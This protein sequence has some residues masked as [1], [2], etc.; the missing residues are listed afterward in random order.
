MFTDTI[1]Y[2]S[3]QQTRILREHEMDLK[4]WDGP[5]IEMLWPQC[6]MTD[7]NSVRKAYN[8]FIDKIE[9]IR[10]QPIDYS[11]FNP[12]YDFKG[13]DVKIVPDFKAPETIMGRCPCP[14]ESETLRCCNLKTL[15]AVQQCAFAC[16]Y[17]SIQSFYSKNEIRVV[18]DLEEQLDS[19]VLDENV[20]HI[21]TGQS[22]DSLLLG[23]DYGTIKALSKFALKHPDVVVELKTKS[24]RTD[25]IK[26]TLPK[27]IV[28]TW[29][30]NAKTI[31][32]KEEH[33][34]ASRDSR[35]SAAKTCSEKGHLV[36]FH[37]HP[38]VYFTD[39]KKEYSELVM[40]LTDTID[41]KMAVMVGMG[42]LTFTKQNLKTLRESGRPTCVTHMPLAPIAGKYSYSNA[43]KQEMFSYIYECFPKEWKDSVFFYLCMEDK[44]LWPLCLGR[45][46]P[47][48]ASFEADM[49][50]HYLNKIRMFDKTSPDLIFLS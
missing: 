22:S 15:D 3:F 31:C 11:R 46:Y 41:P 38:V 50:R 49:K 45:E 14:S 23:D 47:D 40:K 13:K 27:N 35:I 16:A 33:L 32:E 44:A 30:L 7:K 24:A 26:E 1:P 19:I 21:G 10:K 36:G 6:D 39:W 25:W 34:A 12:T 18:S 48:N 20:W 17:C 29:S 9:K 5:Q 43:V 8:T 28:S 4:L 42:T 37:I 2:L